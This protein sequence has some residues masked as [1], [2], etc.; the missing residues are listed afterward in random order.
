MNKT[1]M[2]RA[3]ALWLLKHTSLTGK[4]ISEFCDIH[5]LA[6]DV[7]K[8][9]NTLQELDPIANHQLLR[10]EIQRCECDP[11]AKLMLHNPL[12]LKGKERK[13]YTPLSKRADI[14]HAILWVIKN[15][16]ELPDTQICSI[17][18]TTRSMVKNIR[19]ES[20]WN[21]DHLRPK[22]PVLIGLCREEDLLPA[23]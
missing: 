19:D 10:E 8:N 13:K 5:L 16:P 4:Q 14:P 22:N 2:P 20:Y 1:L 7:L 18:A 3:T 12:I 17:L 21:F 15:H 9:A 11:Q 23:E 6:L